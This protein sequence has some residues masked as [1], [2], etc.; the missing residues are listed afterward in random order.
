MRLGYFIPTYN[1]FDWVV[2]KHLPSLD[3]TLF[4]HIR[5][6]HNFL[7]DKSTLTKANVGSLSIPCVF[8]YSEENLGVARTWNLFAEFAKL[9]ELDVMFIANDDIIL[10]ENTIPKMIDKLKETNS[11]GIVC[12]GGDNGFSLFAVPMSVF[13]TVGKFDENFYPAY[14]EDND[15]VM[16]M[17][18]HKLPIHLLEPPGYYHK[19]SATINSFDEE[20]MQNHHANFRRN[21][22][23]YINKWGGPPG[24]ETIPVYT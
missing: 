23:Y 6:H 2:E 22:Q 20:R 19:G 15:Y 13:N 11:N 12:Y 5:V 9:E 18:L 16:R 3:H 24:K 1:Q 8:T 7:Q 4:S 17:K 21:E 14:F 10:F